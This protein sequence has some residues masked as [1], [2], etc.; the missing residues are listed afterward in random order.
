MGDADGTHALLRLSHDV[1]SLPDHKPPDYHYSTGFLLRME[2]LHAPTVPSGPSS[3]SITNG[4]TAHLSFAELSQ[5]KEN[6]EAELK[7]LG[8]VLES[9]GA[10]GPKSSQCCARHG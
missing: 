5:K 7:A 1:H 3:R 8:G 2:N 6:M 9:V 4:N 10:H